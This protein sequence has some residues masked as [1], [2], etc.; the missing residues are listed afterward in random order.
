MFTLMIIVLIVVSINLICTIGMVGFLL[1][2][3]DMVQE[4]RDESPTALVPPPSQN[5]IDL[6]R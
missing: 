1:R 5:N 2:L 3:A 6:N 4:V